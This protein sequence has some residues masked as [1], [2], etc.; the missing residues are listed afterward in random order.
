MDNEKK[1]FLKQMSEQLLDWDSQ[2]DELKKKAEQAK[3]NVREEYQK[4]I[5]ELSSQKEALKKKFQELNKSGDEAW[6][7]MKNGVEKAASDLKGTFKNAF[8]KFK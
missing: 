3:G 6:E 8:S 7:I 2:V 1:S 4:Q 5:K